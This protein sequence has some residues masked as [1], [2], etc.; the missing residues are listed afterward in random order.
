MLDASL[1]FLAFLDVRL[2]LPADV[3]SFFPTCAI[4]RL[5]RAYNLYNILHIGGEL[6]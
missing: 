6:N 3:V 1:Y 2:V 5:Y 4:G